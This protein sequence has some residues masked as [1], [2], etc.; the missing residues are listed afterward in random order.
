MENLIL[1]GVLLLVALWTAILV[2]YFRY[3]KAGKEDL[4]DDGVLPDGEPFLPKGSVVMCAIYMS[5]LL[6][7]MTVVMG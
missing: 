2:R 4:P 3:S 6:A 5:I 7:I 1:Y